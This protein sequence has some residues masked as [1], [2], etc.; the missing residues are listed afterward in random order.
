MSDPTYLKKFLSQQEID[1]LYSQLIPNIVVTQAI[2]KDI[3]P[4]PEIY[5]EGNGWDV[6]VSDIKIVSPKN[7]S[8]TSGRALS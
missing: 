6:E 7:E 1:N 5:T 8:N 2:I 3:G 4:I